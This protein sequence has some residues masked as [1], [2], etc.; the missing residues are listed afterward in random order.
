MK[1]I[2]LEALD[3]KRL[4]AVAIDA[5]TQNPIVLTGDNGQGKTSVLDAIM[6]ALTRSGVEKPIRNGA[7]SATVAL[8]LSDGSS[9]TYT[10]RR[11][12]KGANAYLDITA[13]DGSKMPSPQKFLDAMIGNLAFDPEAFTRLNAK[14]Q[15]E[16]LR[17][18]VG[19]DTTDLDTA[20]KAA[21]AQRTEANR[22]K[23]IAEKA[24]KG[25]PVV[26]NQPLE[27]KDA[28]ALVKQRDTLDADLRMRDTAVDALEQCDERISQCQVHIK[29]LEEKLRTVREALAQHEEER[30]AYELSV[31]KR[32]EATKDHEERIAKLN[33]ELAGITEHNAKITEHN[34]QIEDRNTKHAAYQTALKRATELDN[35][36]KRIVSEKEQRI[37]AAKFPVPG[38]AIE[39]DTVMVNNVPFS[40]LNT[41]ERIKISTLI[42]MAQNPQL[43]VI[44]VRE[45]ALVSRANL[46][47]LADLAK[48][49]E[50]QIFIEKFN[51]EPEDDSIHIEDGSV[52]H[53]NG[54]PAEA[55]QLTLV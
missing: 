27:P 45:G 52:T 1:L 37:A 16:A 21:Y 48:E 13:E 55:Q 32:T 29:S 25:C 53:I 14:Q 6:W 11:K 18:A 31:T 50:M 19:L 5:D 15:A 7:E 17:Q 3:F 47:V 54:K 23:D 9:R 28:A 35:E 40:D 26:S 39:D 22:V 10:V 42:A 30:V 46:A 43:K 4:S 38:L 34:R 2:R 51:E 24:Y 20:H 49:H 8:T 41:A 44:F 33:E 12:A 36:V